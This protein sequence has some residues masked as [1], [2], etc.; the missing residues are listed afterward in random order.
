MTNLPLILGCALISIALAQQSQP[1]GNTE[2]KKPGSLQGQVTNAKTGEPVR[3]VNL[4]LRPMPAPGMG[5]GISMSMAPA[6]PFAAT[7]DAEGKFRIENVEPGNY[8][9][10]AE[11]QGFV[12][13][14]YGARPNAM[15]GTTIHVSSG[16]E[17]KDLGF[18]LTPQAVVIGRVLDEEGEPIARAQIQVLRSR[19]NQGKKQLL[20]MGGGQTMDTGEFRVADLAPGRY[21]ISAVYRN[22]MMAMMMNEGPARNTAGKPEE[23]YVTT[24]Y[25]SSTDEAG[26]R[27]ID[28]VAGQ[29]MSGIDIRLQKARVYRVRGKIAGGTQPVRNM[30]VM[31]MPRERNMFTG[32]FGGGGG[33]VKEDGT[34][35]IGSVQPGSYYVVAV[36]S[37]GMMSINGKTAV[38]V[39]QEDVANVVLNLAA[40]T[41]IK[42]VI[43]L[44]S[45]LQQQQQSQTNKITLGS[46]RVQLSPVDGIVF[47]TPGA[48]AKDDG[49]FV[50][51]NAGPETYRILAYG[52]PPGVWLKSIRAG[53]Q[54]VLDRGIDLSGGAPAPIEITLSGGVGQITGVVQDAKQ[55]P[56]PGSMVTLLPD[57]LKV[58]RS[59]LL[60]VSS[61]DQNGQFTLQSIAPGD[62]KLYAWE[63]VEPGR[64]MDPEFLKTHESS[65]KK[66]SIKANGQEQATLTQ[67]S[68]D[69]TGPR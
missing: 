15:M 20:P 5:G 2:A 62:Y 4:T 8:R 16:Q 43:K 39:S 12:R 63:D 66:I 34:F 48:T 26:A 27:A 11:R 65:A 32:M 25:P 58:E 17:L 68:A 49:S 40:G 30:R 14:E 45:D 6:A 31:I 7:T 36:P 50:I 42:G 41:T 69:A 35:E 47:N 37:Q 59:D 67:I 38:D 57:P 18:K 13:G 21:W 55:Q 10:M 60:R 53:D 9:L 1:T 61:A 24:Y 29:E 51:E 3:R 22:R 33:V 54:D 23:E 28:L 44:D 52:L 46:V 64:Y 56:A 19:F